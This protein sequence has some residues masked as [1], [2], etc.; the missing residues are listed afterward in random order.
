MFRDQE[1]VRIAQVM[2]VVHLH[3]STCRCVPLSI[4]RKRLDGLRCNLVRVA[5]VRSPFPYLGNGWRDCAE[6]W[7]VLMGP[8]A[9]RFVGITSGAHCTCARAH[10]YFYISVAAGRFV[11]KF[12]VLLDTH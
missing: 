9:M 1:V 4:S 3:V 11:L 7:C 2:G 12:G 8:I 5:H 10:H 6:I